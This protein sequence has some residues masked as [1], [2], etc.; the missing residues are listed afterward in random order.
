MLQHAQ[1]SH[2]DHKYYVDLNQLALAASRYACPVC[3]GVTEFARHQAERP[4]QSQSA[5]EI[6]QLIGVGAT[7]VGLI[8]FLDRLTGWRPA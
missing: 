6:W 2:C 5:R 4:E 1:C 8:M 7:V 3:Y